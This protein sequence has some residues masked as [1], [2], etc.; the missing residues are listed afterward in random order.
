MLGIFIVP[1]GILG[2]VGWPYILRVFKADLYA[3][4]VVNMFPA[5]IAIVLFDNEFSEPF[6]TLATLVAI[7]AFNANTIGILSYWNMLGLKR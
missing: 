6:G 7:A 2:A 1:A 5:F 3:A 4:L